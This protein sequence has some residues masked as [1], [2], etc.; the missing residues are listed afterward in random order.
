LERPG[1]IGL[2]EKELS[3]R[4]N[5]SIFF[6]KKIADGQPVLQENMFMKLEKLT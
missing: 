4:E 2:P 1:W 3:R 5:L 6:K